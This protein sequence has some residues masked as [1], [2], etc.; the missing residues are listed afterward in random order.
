MSRREF[1]TMLGGAVAAWPVAAH[2]RQDGRRWCI[3]ALA[4]LKSAVGRKGLFVADTIPT[5]RTQ[6]TGVRLARLQDLF[7]GTICSV[8]SVAYCLSFATLIFSGPLSGWLGYGIAIGLLST[9]IGALVIGL[10]S[11]LPIAIAGPDSPTSAV[12]AVLV[13]DFV[14]R[15]VAQ[16]AGDDLLK[17]A[18][19]LMALVTALTGAV[20]LLLG[21]TRAGRAIRFVPYPVIGGF[22]GATGW[23]IAAGGAQVTSG[24]HFT[25]DS[26][27]APFNSSAG[28]KLLAGAAVAITLFLGRRWLRSS[29]ALPGLLLTAVAVVHLALLS[30]GVPLAE[31]Q[32]SGWMFGPQSDVGLVAPWHGDELRRFP[33]EMLPSLSGDILS[34][35]F[36]VAITLLLNT[37]GI[38]LA[39]RREADLDRELKSHGIANLIIAALGGY[40]S[41]TSLS[42]TT[43]NYL[44]G[45]TGR[46]SAMTVAAI[47][48][49]V[50][51]VDS[52]FLGYVPKCVLGGLL[53]YLGAD[54]LY[55]WLVDS[56]RR[57][58]VPEYLS[59]LA[60]AF[61]II[62][63]GFVAGL[64]IGVVIGCA[65]FAF[66]A[67]RVPVIKFS[68]DGSEYRSSLDRRPEELAVLTD[69]GDELQGMSLQ[70]YLF[71]GS[72]SR[73]H[74]HIKA[75][76]AAR[77][78]C[79]FLLFDLRLVTGIDS[80]ATNSFRQIKQ[81]ADG[82][83]TRLA[84]VSMTREIESTFRNTGVISDGVLVMSDLDHALEQC[85]NAIINAHHA[86]GSEA[87]S[88]LAWL[89]QMVGAEH[90]YHLAKECHRLEV[91]AG[92]IIVRQGHTADAM[93]FILEGRVS[94]V[95]NGGNRPKVRVRSLGPHT[96]IGEMG[97]IAGQVRSATIEAEVDS[98]L[99]VL[100]ADAFER[101]RKT[102]PALLQA[103]LAYVVTVMTERLSFANR[104]IE[105]LQR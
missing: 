88:L 97:L 87:R 11:T 90:A 75:L 6:G 38:E 50:I 23:L 99:Y 32:A 80:S 94:V 27:G 95:V 86:P 96:T 53:F 60:I 73:L 7:A 52:S 34:V 26:A 31:A 1:I 48:A 58:A 64:L 66:S 28:A 67:S 36:V 89:V 63:W 5:D 84:L 104:A 10:R 24:H 39:A 41:V 20:L 29:F 21:L 19:M 71:F 103:L 51:A 9:S 35:V 79:R 61:I 37:T 76:L 62:K 56:S 83:G 15:L 40:I 92:E 54:L 105:A 33:W 70:G 45:A 85:E 77:P 22:L 3:G 69:H 18:V 30:F 16:G 102:N 55:R 17:H 91:A 47:S 2:T 100:K 12:L 57:L 72:A 25:I 46:I 78:R 101:V 68:F 4:R 49:A 59:L 81:V 98:V 43:V 82:Y 13:A 8:L 42:R 14:R 44:A 74:E 65:T 93:H